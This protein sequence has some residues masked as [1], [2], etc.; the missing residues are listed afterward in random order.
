MTVSGT[1]RMVA[2][3][4]SH[5]APCPERESAGAKRRQSPGV[6][7]GRKHRDHDEGNG[8]AH[9]GRNGKPEGLGAARLRQP[10]RAGRLYP[11]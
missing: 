6:Y 11:G 9:Q 5:D 8:W 3:K 1:E 4:A 2:S 7:L 10:G